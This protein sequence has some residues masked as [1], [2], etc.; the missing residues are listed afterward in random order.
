MALTVNTTTMMLYL[1][2][3]YLSVVSAS[4]ST[5]SQRPPFLS[6]VSR[7]TLLDTLQKAEGYHKNA[8]QQAL[9]NYPVNAVT[10]EV[11]QELI[12]NIK[13]QEYT[14]DAPGALPDFQKEL[15]RAVL[16]TETPLLTAEECN[17]V[18]QSANEHFQQTTETGE[19]SQLPSGQYMVAGFWIKD[20]PS[21]QEWFLKTVKTRLFPLLARQFP[22]FVQ[23][24]DN[25][26]V[27]NA[28]LFKYTPETGGRTDV[29][30][31]SG[32]LSFTLA[33]NPKSD[34]EGGGTWFD[35]LQKES[36]SSS[37]DCVIEMD[38]GQVTIRPGGVKHCGYAVE[39]GERYI[40]GGFCMHQ[41]K[42]EIVRQI[43][44]HS[45]QKPLEEIVDDIS[46]LE[47]AIVLN[48]KFDSAYNLLAVA[49]E[50]QHKANHEAKRQEIL[51]YCLQ[52]V[53]S[54]A[55]DVSYALGSLYRTASPP[56]LSKAKECFVK[57]LEADSHDV[58]AMIALM[59][60]AA[61]EQNTDEERTMAERILQCSVANDK[62]KA[63]AY[64][65]LGV[66]HEGQGD[67]ELEYYQKAIKLQPHRFPPRYSLACAYASN[68]QWAEATQ[69]FRQ[70]LEHAKDTMTPEQR[71]QTLQNL[72]KT[73]MHV[74]QQQVGNAKP[75]QA[76]I[77]ELFRQVMG[78]EHFDALMKMRQ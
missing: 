4:S 44:A 73:S 26:C 15:P 21:V 29:H 33:L 30:T 76:E 45:Q 16:V 68:Q 22:E 39:S 13:L 1:F 10:E 28:Y 2:W 71:M 50:Q 27:D 57:C 55:G 17:Q 63:Q 5:T 78:G 34:Y 23:D 74:I 65:N 42:P 69:H 32:C 62:A 51:E 60:V 25:L 75:S 41:K 56:N 24:P 9:E 11:D 77:M 19:W 64:C 61:D 53:N 72:Y 48:P 43:M 46:Q 18:I 6:H 59:M 31:D 66:L 8:V 52:N 14:I 67:K 47:S 36:S 3:I 20:I 37:N 35:G 58:E 12:Q 38:Q 49:L 70:A 7:E 40:I 54:Y